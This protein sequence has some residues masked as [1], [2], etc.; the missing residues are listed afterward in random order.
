VDVVIDPD[1]FETRA[2]HTLID[3]RDTD[4]VEVG[5]GDG[6]M[7][8]RFADEASTVL[9]IEPSAAQ[10][11]RAVEGTPENLRSTVRFVQADATTYRYPSTS[12]D[13]AVLSFSL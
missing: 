5:S 1:G 7:T 6:R 10:V 8:W 13:V 2:I 11:A 12:F 3:F 4:V 9:A